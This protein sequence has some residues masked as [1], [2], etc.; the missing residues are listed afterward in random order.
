MELPKQI[1]VDSHISLHALEEKDAANLFRLTDRNRSR[2]KQWL[3]W[4]DQTQTSA[5]TLRFIQKSQKAFETKTGFQAKILVRGQM[6]GM[7]GLH[8]IDWVN[9]KTSIGYWLGA[10]FE[11]RGIM[12]R[13]CRALIDCL[14]KELHLNRV[15]IRMAPANKK[16]QAIAKKLG[17][18]EEG[19][20]R[21]YE[22]LYTQFADHV[23]YSMLAKDWNKN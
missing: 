20:L 2:L 12:V 8:F 15:E 1:I 21:Q 4:L 3:A 14:F 6:A 22:R 18:I 9:A 7:I 19:T 11:G 10:E 16:S 13:S 5:D 23:S 17:F